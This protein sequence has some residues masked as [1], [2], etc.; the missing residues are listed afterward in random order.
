MRWLLSIVLCF[1]VLVSHAFAEPP[2]RARA[3]GP[4]IRPQDQRSTQ[5]LRDGL[6]RSET[7]RALVDRIEASNVFVYVQVSPFIKSSLAGQ[8]TWMTQAGPYRYVRATLSPEQTTD[9]SIASLAH[10]LQHAVEVVED[11]L[12][13]NETTLVSLYKRIGRPSSAAVASGWETV[14]AQEAGYQ[15]RR[16]LVAATSASV[17]SELF[18]PDHL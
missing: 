14:A 11:A 12:V 9:Q 2:G 13:V 5:L 8:L 7:F 4:R 17:A 1:A 10:E 16:E 15:V 18:D 6:A 3:G